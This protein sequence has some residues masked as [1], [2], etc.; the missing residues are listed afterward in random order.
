MKVA[1]LA[2]WKI[3]PQG[4]TD[5]MR[6]IVLMA[7]VAVVGVVA[8]D[9]FFVRDSLFSSEKAWLSEP[10]LVR[11]EVGSSCPLYYPRDDS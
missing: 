10:P 8:I 6:M 1:S 9:S 4:V 7:I 5:G 3:L 11:F 2:E